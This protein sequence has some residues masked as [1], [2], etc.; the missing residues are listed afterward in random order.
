M[1]AL[2]YPK[3]GSDAQLYGFLGTNYHFKAGFNISVSVGILNN[4]LTTDIE[5]TLY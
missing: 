5:G 2:I 1:F 4:Q 3:N